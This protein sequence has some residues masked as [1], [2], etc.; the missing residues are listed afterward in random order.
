MK[1]ITKSEKWSL[2]KVAECCV[3][4]DLEDSAAL[5]SEEVAVEQSG[6][7]F[8]GTCSHAPLTDLSGSVKRDFLWCH[9]FVH[10]LFN[11]IFS[12]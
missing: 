9:F 7:H 2:R 3:G 12:C 1:E 5:G 8:L 4:D 11:K 10:L 6:R